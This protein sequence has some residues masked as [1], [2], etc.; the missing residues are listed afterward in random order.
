MKIIRIIL[1]VLVAILSIIFLTAFFVSLK[2]PRH[3]RNWEDDSKILPHITISTS[4][5]AVGNIR[6]W[7]Y[8]KDK[9]V[10]MDYYDDTFDLEKIKGGIILEK[11]FSVE[12]AELTANLKI[13]R[14]QIE[15]NYQNEI[16]YLYKK[17]ELIPRTNDSFFEELTNKKGYYFLCQ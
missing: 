7:R 17:I 4:T 15:E 10:S 8:E 5:V 16:E 13:R 2:T 6:D 3:D 11:N 1:W 14:K 9:V 12:N